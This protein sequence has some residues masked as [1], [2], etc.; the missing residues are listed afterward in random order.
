MHSICFFLTMTDRREDK[1]TK[2]T[3]YNIC[4]IKSATNH[5]NK[6]P[7]HSW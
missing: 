4:R 2:A 1:K 7:E 6:Y 3:K 5:G